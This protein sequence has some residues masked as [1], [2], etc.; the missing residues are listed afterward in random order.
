MQGERSS[1]LGI[2]KGPYL[3]GC[4]SYAV[5]ELCVDHLRCHVQ[6]KSLEQKLHDVAND[7]RIGTSTKSL[8]RL[9]KKRAALEADLERLANRGSVRCTNGSEP[10]VVNS[11]SDGFN[12]SIR[13]CM[14]P[15][16]QR[17]DDGG[18]NSGLSETSTNESGT[19]ASSASNASTLL[20]QNAT[21]A[22][23]AE[24]SATVPKSSLKVSVRTPSR[25]YSC[26]PV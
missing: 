20:S 25:S 21:N 14:G 8:S 4:S 22:D 3:V 26:F 16:K 6:Y 13:E 17:T 9:N 18:S 1:T 10:T 23:A 19:N 11:S 2:S 12:Q 15:K 24:A 7:A 5:V